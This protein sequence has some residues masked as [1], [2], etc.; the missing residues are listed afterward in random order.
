MMGLP[1]MSWFSDIQGTIVKV[2]EFV[3]PFGNPLF[4]LIHLLL[5]P[6][7]FF[8]GLLMV[9]FTQKDAL[10]AALHAQLVYITGLIPAYSLDYV[11]VA[12]I[13]RV[14]PLGE[15]LGMASALVSLRLAA[16]ALRIVKSWIPTVN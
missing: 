2:W 13:N 5:S 9:W 8:V 4:S 12:Q 7:S 14:F 10:Y 11:W 15:S 3:K 1:Q 16:A 6:A